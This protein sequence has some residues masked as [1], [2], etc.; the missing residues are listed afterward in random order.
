MSVFYL[1]LAGALA[2]LGIVVGARWL[3]SR[4]W[5]KSLFAFRLRLPAGLS[6]D[7]VTGFL[8][9]VNAS[10]H[11][12]LFSVL[13]VPPVAVELV[14]SRTGIEHVL[15][16][17]KGMRDSLL[18][19]LRASLPGVRVEALPD[20]LRERPRFRVAAEASLSNQRRPLGVDRAE[21][22][23]AALLA[24]LQ[25]L[26][27][28]E[29][30]VVQW[31]MTG[32]GIPHPVPSVSASNGKESNN[33]SLGG[34]IAMESEA[35]RAERLKQKEPLLR[36]SLR[37]GVVAADRKR[38]YNIYGRVWASLRLLN[39]PGVG[40][41]RRWWLPVGLVAER[42]QQLAMPI[43]GWPLVINTRE[44]A[45]LIG[46]PVA[47]VQLP[48]LSL[49]AARQLPVSVAM[50]TRGA[51]FG[52]SNYP[53]SEHRPIALRP[54]DRL[55][56]TWIVGPTGAGKSTLLGNLIVQDMR[57]G[58]GMV[59]VDA[60]G[61]LITDVLARVPESR[62]DDIIVLDPSQ[63]ARPVGFNVLTI[64]KGEQGRELAVDH[65]LHIF[66]DLYRSSWGPRTADIL[67]A[68]LLTLMLTRAPDGSA[69]TLVELPELLTNDRFRASVIQQAA[70]NR[71][72]PELRS[73]WRWYQGLSE[74][75]RAQVVG[76][77]LN[78]LRAFVLKTPLK[79]LLGQSNGLDLNT[80][81]TERK[82]L[83]VPL[84]K[85]VL[86][87]ETAQLVGSL[88]V[89]SVWQL[90][91]GRARIAPERRRPVWLYADEF[92]ETVRLPI[93]LAD[94]LAQAR[95][96]GLGLTLAHQ[97]LGQLP[98][99]LKAAVMGTSR[100]QLAFQLDYADATALSRSFAPLTRDDLMGLERFEMA[101][102]PCVDG[103]TLFPVTVT[104]M[105][106]PP[107]T[108]EA[109]ELARYSHL[110]HGVDRADVI[111]ALQARIAT[112]KPGGEPGRQRHGGAA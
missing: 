80:I 109:A 18:S 7:A 63:V 61:D 2:I 10:T 87:P 89:A 91:L 16:V 74:A 41:V 90:A 64:A 62:R 34:P 17:S 71:H 104:T 76:P 69:F 103:R 73:F 37:V 97:H 4:S 35:V 33:W 52:T 19:G 12:N 75:E 31:I 68:S 72:H 26:H 106:L 93:D 56:H 49:G 65:V 82:I 86:G 78:K 102:R 66:Q 3:E 88:L 110:H 13:A 79:L 58:S 55:R 101:M 27:G 105:P 1:M 14:A 44:L 54:D 98:E 23:S 92:Q 50:P 42:I 28:S 9:T 108:Q 96:L 53:G 77:V 25:P 47:N 100:S 111:A 95:G 112:N 24:S 38:A 60:R 84:S 85:G 94:M 32:G 43:V 67:R 21:V 51:V 15:L 59:V 22:A 70:I 81:F 11:A 20:Y 107:A 40:I 46:F 57:A 29:R 5:P 8:S 83:L 39:A 30:I 99:V 48:G 45:G 36:A 6:V